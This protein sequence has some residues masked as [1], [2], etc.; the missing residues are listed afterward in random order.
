M[1][2]AQATVSRPA[3]APPAA[4]PAPPHGWGE[5]LLLVAAGA[6]IMLALTLPAFRSYFFA[7]DFMYVGQLRAHGDNFWRAVFSPTDNIFFR[8]VFCA[9]NLLS[10]AVLPLDPFVHHVRNWLFS[11]L[12]LLLLYRIL[13]RLVGNRLA[14]VLGLAFFAVSKI[15]LTAIGYIN[16]YDSIISLALLLA[17]VL[18]FL[19]FAA[20]RRARDYVLGL[21]FC[22][23]SV[24]TK[25]YGLV[26]VGVVGAL[27]AF[28]AP[29]PA[30]WRTW[31][32]WWAPRL[33][34]LPAMIVIYLALR[35]VIV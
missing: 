21:L 4:T 29:A 28:Q 24:F 18:C 8:P 26:V 34:P 31:R 2:R 3:L 15:H 7:E 19:R 10:M 13:L 5:T 33:A 23:L 32:R 1:A 9:V 20:G 22:F 12:D 35:Y 17:T 25:D 16:V 11:A 27:V 14:R 30:D 6:A